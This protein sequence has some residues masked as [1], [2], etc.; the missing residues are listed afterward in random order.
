[1]AKKQEK[2]EH[3]FWIGFFS[4]LVVMFVIVMLISVF[5]QKECPQEKDLIPMLCQEGA[6]RCSPDIEGIKQ[7]CVN[8]TW[9]NWMPAE[10]CIPTDCDA[11]DFKDVIFVHSINCP[12]CQTMMPIIE[13]MEE[14]GYKFFWA[15]SSTEEKKDTRDCYGD[16]L[17]G[18]VPEFICSSNKEK[19]VGARPKEELIA[20]IN[21]NCTMEE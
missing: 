6:Q 15:E 1:M 19:L 10:E 20:W 21:E 17:S 13:D 8:N 18:A 16:V 7:K 11:I 5:W 2:D 3:T 9:N 4:G 12:H 14:E